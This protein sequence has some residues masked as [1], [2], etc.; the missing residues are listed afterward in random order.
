VFRERRGVQQLVEQ[1]R[2]RTDGPCRLTANAARGVWAGGAFAAPLPLPPPPSPPPAEWVGGGSAAHPRHFD[3]HAGEAS[4]AAAAK[5][6]GLREVSFRFVLSRFI[7]YIDRA[8]CVFFYS[9]HD[10]WFILICFVFVCYL[11]L[12]IEYRLC[13]QKP[14]SST[15]N[16]LPS[17]KS[18]PNPYHVT[19]QS[20]VL[21]RGGLSYSSYNPVS[22][23]DSE[24]Q[25]LSSDAYTSDSASVTNSSV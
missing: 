22:R 13:L 18:L 21:M 15:T 6:R 5:T 8:T 3:V 16:T 19:S 7:W 17:S 14:T 1:Q 24:L 12:P 4:A 25:S 9:Q 23:Q 20:S 2:Q 10:F 11:M